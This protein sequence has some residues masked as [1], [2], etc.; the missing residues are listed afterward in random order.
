MTYTRRTFLKTA[1]IAAI[2]AAFG[3]ITFINQEKSVLEEKIY[4][5][6]K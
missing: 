3:G 4:L 1:G 2:L 6:R 5:S